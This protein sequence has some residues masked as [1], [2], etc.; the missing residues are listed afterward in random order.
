M[1]KDVHIGVTV[2]CVSTK[3]LNDL[4]CDS[5]IKLSCK[6]QLEVVVVANALDYM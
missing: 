2:T 6:R 1:N 4:K 3:L 5:Y